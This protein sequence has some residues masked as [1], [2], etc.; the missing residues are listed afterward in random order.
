MPEWISG[1][2]KVILTRRR[3]EMSEKY[4]T[5]DVG[6]MVTGNAVEHK[7]GGDLPKLSFGNLLL[8]QNIEVI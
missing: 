8:I 6:S 1:S 7:H 3:N 4:N 5:V 2:I